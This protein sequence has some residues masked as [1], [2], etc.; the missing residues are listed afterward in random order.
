MIP[1]KKS[2]DLGSRPEDYNGDSEQ[3]ENVQVESLIFAV[4]NFNV[5]NGIAVFDCMDS[6]DAASV[7][8]ATLGFIANKIKE[9]GVKNISKAVVKMNANGKK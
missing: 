9:A 3:I 4:K 6:I 1:D 8:C 2:Y 7:K 5:I